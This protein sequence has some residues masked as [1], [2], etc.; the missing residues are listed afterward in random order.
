[1]KITNFSFVVLKALLHKCVAESFY[2]Q[3]YYQQNAEN[4]QNIL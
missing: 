1:M 3:N 2:A 4:E